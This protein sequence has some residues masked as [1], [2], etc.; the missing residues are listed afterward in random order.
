M[1]RRVAPLRATRRNTPEE[2]IFSYVTKVLN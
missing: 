1:L 2:R